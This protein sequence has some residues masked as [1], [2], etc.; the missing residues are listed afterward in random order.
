MVNQPS[1]TGKNRED[2]P[3]THGTRLTGSLSTRLWVRPLWLGNG[4]CPS[5]SPGIL[6]TERTCSIG[7]FNPWCNALSVSIPWKIS[8]ISLHAQPHCCSWYGKTCSPN[9]INGWGSKWP[10][11]NWWRTSLSACISDIMWPLAKA[12]NKALSMAGWPTGGCLGWILLLMVGCLYNG[13][14]SKMNFGLGLG[15]TN[16][17]SG[18][19]PN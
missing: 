9:Y 13:N 19:H 14:T 8:I 3:T 2:S 12:R 15:T 1:L 17:V 6:H 16:W 10:F 5:L 4:G 11:L 7:I 18:G